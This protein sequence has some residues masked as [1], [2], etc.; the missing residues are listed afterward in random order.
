MSSVVDRVEIRCSGCGIEK[1]TARGKS[2][3]KLPPSWKRGDSGEPICDGCWKSKYVLR[4]IT[5]PVAGPEGATWAEFR[6]ALHLCWAGATSVA[7]WAVAELAK[8]DVIRT[9]SMEKMPKAPKVALYAL[10]NQHFGSWSAAGIDTGTAAT[11]CQQIQSKYLRRRMESIWQ[12]KAALPTYRYPYP[13]PIRAQDWDL[14]ELREGQ[15]IGVN[16]R[17]GG[18]RWTIRLRGGAQFGRQI[19]MLRRLMN[20]EGRAVEMTLLERR[21]TESDNRPGNAGADKASNATKSRVMVKIAAWIPRK[22]DGRDGTMTVRTDPDSFLV[23]LIGEE[24]LWNYHADHLRRWMSEHGRRS[25]R[26]SDDI[27]LERRRGRARKEMFESRQKF[28]RK[29]NDRIDSAIHEISRMVVGVADRRKL[30]VLRYDDSCR[31]YI[32]SFPYDCLRQRLQYKAEELGIEFVHANA[33]AV[34]K[35]RKS[36]AKSQ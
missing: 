22:E 26:F 27:K 21:V 34:K 14:V 36:L 1:S 15:S 23:A 28:C 10:G 8:A 13:Y 5:V 6:E 3:A 30:A 7:N 35:P 18:R 11:I 29:Q 9:P 32:R 24:K 2:D 31:E 12:R 17:M 25:Q 16:C 19:G 33:P 20:G 4:A